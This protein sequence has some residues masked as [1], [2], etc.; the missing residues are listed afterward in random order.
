MLKWCSYC[1]QFQ[2]EIP[3]Y[4]NFA[5]THGLCPSCES[6]HPN[7]F[8]S[9]VVRHSDFL[10]R[11]F[12][13]LYEAGRRNDF[14]SAERLV[15]E[16][17][18]AHCRPV[19]VLIGVLAPLLY[20]I[21]EQ[22]QSG[23]ITVSQEHEF[24]AFSERVIDLVEG[25]M[26]Q[27]MTRRPASAPRYLLMNAPGNT[28]MLAIRI[29]ALWLESGS[30]HATT[31]PDHLDLKELAQ[32][33]VKAAPKALLISMSLPEQ[34]AAVASISALVGGLPG[35]LRPSV[36][37]G[38]YAVKSGL[39]RSVPGADLITDITFL[40]TSRQV[41]CGCGPELPMTRVSDTSASEG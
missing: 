4:G 2:G 29:L 11:I 28:H 23:D 19:D 21:G 7:V 39:V 41:I 40:S 13:S 22:W 6:A 27:G 26:H 8:A 3:P 38:G 9:D 18:A 37:V 16:A 31:I 15:E 1:Q 30:I 36:I 5:I 24:T 12:R 25:K 10:R 33:I 17:I 35:R 34:L 20:K 14:G 32:R